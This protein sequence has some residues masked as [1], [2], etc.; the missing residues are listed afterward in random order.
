LDFAEK[1]FKDFELDAALDRC[2]RVR[3]AL[4]AGYSF[5]LVASAIETIY[6]V[7]EDQLS[8]RHAVYVPVK[9]FE[10]F[11]EITKLF[12]ASVREAFPSIGFDVDGACTSYALD[13][14]NASVYHAMGIVQRGLYAFAE[15]LKIPFSTSAHTSVELENWKNIID[16]I[17]AA[18]K[19]LEGMQKGLAK[20][21][22]VTFYSRTAIQFRYFKDAWRNHVDHNR[23]IYD[24]DQAHSILIHARD[25]IVE[26]ANHGL[27]DPVSPIG[28]P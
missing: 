12:P 3:Y 22:K 6:Q 1:Q 10:Y 7:A 9:K 26:L 17:D 20:D 2:K 8:R 11:F 5:D 16:Q 14:N 28:T 21:E 4:E 27:H 19:K 25:F 15:E 18:I 13:L 23:E 24:A